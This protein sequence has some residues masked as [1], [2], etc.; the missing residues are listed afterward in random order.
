MYC[1]D[2]HSE[3]LTFC[4]VLYTLRNKRRYCR[5]NF[6]ILPVAIWNFRTLGTLVGETKFFVESPWKSENCVS[7]DKQ[8]IRLKIAEILGGKS[9]ELTFWVKLARWF[10]FLEIQEN[11]IGIFGRME[12]VWDNLARGAL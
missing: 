8:I 4:D 1:N 5:F 12:S 3:L 9:M 10:S 6:R 2:T 7:S 11:E